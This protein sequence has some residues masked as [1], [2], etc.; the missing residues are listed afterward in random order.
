MAK[1]VEDTTFYVYN[2]FVSS[3]EVG[4]DTKSFGITLEQWHASNRGAARRCR[5][6]RC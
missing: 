1:G 2:R 3:N 6:T 5:R 4:G